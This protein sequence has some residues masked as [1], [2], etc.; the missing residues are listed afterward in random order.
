[1]TRAIR[2]P[3][4]TLK[5]FIYGLAIEDGFV[6]PESLIDDRPIRYGSYAPENFDLT[7]QGTVSARR[8][9]QLSLNVPAVELLEAVGPARLIARLRSAGAGIALP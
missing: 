9:L 7:Y 1:M 6:H 8:A 2:S 4:S 5:P 3:G